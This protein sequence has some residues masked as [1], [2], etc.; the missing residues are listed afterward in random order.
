M[1]LKFHGSLLMTSLDLLEK[2]ED[3]PTG[4]R[5]K[6]QHKFIFKDF[7]V[8]HSCKHEGGHTWSD[9]CCQDRVFST[10]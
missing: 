9:A 3:H 1:I 10:L 8:H 2:R 7:L 5:N 6:L 4:T